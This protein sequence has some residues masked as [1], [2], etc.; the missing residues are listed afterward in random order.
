[1]WCCHCWLATLLDVRLKSFRQGG[2]GID[3]SQFLAEHSISLLYRLLVQLLKWY[4]KRG[5][6]FL[7]CEKPKQSTTHSPFTSFDTL[8]KRTQLLPSG[9][10]AFHP[11]PAKI[12]NSQKTP[13]FHLFPW[14]FLLATAHWSLWLQACYRNLAACISSGISVSSPAGHGHPGP[15]L[16]CSS[17]ASSHPSFKTPGAFSVSNSKALYQEAVFTRQYPEV[18]LYKIDAYVGTTKDYGIV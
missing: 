5:S 1:M 16:L 17:W 4:M 7:N 14:C 2:K 3:C 18:V 8:N 15:G 9:V 6:P 11:G 10:C 12:P 13:G